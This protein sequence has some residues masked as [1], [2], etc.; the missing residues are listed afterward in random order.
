[1][2][3]HFL[4]GFTSYLHARH[5]DLIGIRARWLLSTLT[6]RSWGSHLHFSSISVDFLHYVDHIKGKISNV[7]CMPWAS[8]RQATNSHVLVSHRFHLRSN[9]MAMMLIFQ[10]YKQSFKVVLFLPAT[11]VFCIW[12]QDSSNCCYLC[13]HV[14]SEIMIRH[15]RSARKVRARVIVD[16][17]ARRGG[18]GGRKNSPVSFHFCP[19]PWKQTCLSPRSCCSTLPTKDIR[20]SQRHV[21]LMMICELSLWSPYCRHKSYQLAIK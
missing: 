14:V 17:K 19:T 20:I 9:I 21:V 15:H 18:W 16:N 6:P 13:L 7:D 10:Q 8:C 1:M 12:L 11:S 4:R 3:V 5:C 2:H